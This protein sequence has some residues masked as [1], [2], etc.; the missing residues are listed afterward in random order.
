MLM[1]FVWLHVRGGYD[2]NLNYHLKCYWPWTYI[3]NCKD[4]G[5][6]DYFHTQDGCTAAIQLTPL[7]KKVFNAYQLLR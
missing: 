3:H 6:I 4:V 2:T 1:D 7:G 5:L